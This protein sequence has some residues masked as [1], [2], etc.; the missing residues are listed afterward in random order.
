MPAL[1]ARR[2]GFAQAHTQ[3]LGVSID[4]I[5][6]H[7]NWAAH[8][9]GG[10]SFPLLSD[11]HPKGAVAEAY[12]LY[13]ADKGIT[14]R[15]SVLIDASGTVVW[16]E[17]VTP[18]GKRDM[19]VL[20]ERCRALDAEYAGPVEVRKAPGVPA[21]AELFVKTGCPFSKATLNAR[22]NLHLEDAITVHNITETPEAGDRLEA[23]GG[24]R[25]VP[26][27]VR[28]DEAL[29]ESTEIVGYLARQVTG[30]EST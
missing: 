21:G 10:I 30:I 15:A 7:A 5:H 14:D 22:V 18:A 25:Q 4:S 24:K 13:L 27:L 20:L 23:I 17:S 6:C 26:C 2:S 9:L 11:F 29:Y 8:D 12:G 19:D 28:G 16:S 1:E 3:V